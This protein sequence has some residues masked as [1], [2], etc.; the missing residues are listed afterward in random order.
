MKVLHSILNKKVQIFLSLILI[1]NLIFLVQAEISK[2]YLIQST[3]YIR[4]AK[5]VVKGRQII[6]QY[7]QPVLLRGFSLW[8]PNLFQEQWHPF[9]TPERF[10]ELKSWGF[11]VINIVV[12][13][14]TI[15]RSAD[16]IGVYDEAR[17]Q[18]LE[19]V[20]EWIQDAGLYVVISLRVMNLWW[21]MP[22]A[23]EYT[24]TEECRIRYAN[25]LETIVKRF[26]HY[27][28]LIGYNGWHFP[29]HGYEGKWSDPAWKDSYY[30]VYTPIIVNTIRAHSNKIIFYSLIYQGG[31][32]P[33]SKDTGAFDS[34]TPLSDTNVVYCHKLHNPYEVEHEP[35][36]W[37]YDYDYVKSLIQPAIDFQ[38]KYN[39]PLA[40][41]EFGMEIH[42]RCGERPIRQSRLDCLDYKLQ[43]M[44]EQGN[45]HWV[46][47]IYTKWEPEGC[48]EAVLE[49]DGT[50]TQ[51][52]DV[53]RNHTTGS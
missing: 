26:D 27:E 42:D 28:N 44:D 40:C 29:Y 51:V 41:W 34:L 23:I 47:W 32:G 7:G 46:Y 3:G 17:L 22:T 38:N 39:V 11:N 20:I 9:L 14:A 30:N 21:D 25:F 19:E 45:Y 33:R 13:W 43:L 31:W 12:P 24:M 16:Q 10:Q 2:T 18:R 52:M 53:L 49:E 15:E 1:F 4:Y 8:W 6:D 50:P 48:P 37:D 35:V 5:L 36:D